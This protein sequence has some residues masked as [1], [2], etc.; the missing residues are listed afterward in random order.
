MTAGGVTAAFDRASVRLRPSRRGELAL[1]VKN[2]TT[3]Q[4][5]VA[6]EVIGAPAAWASLCPATFPL[7]PRATT[8][9]TLTLNLPS[10]SPAAGRYP[11]QVLAFVPPDQL[12]QLAA[13]S[14]RVPRKLGWRP[15]LAASAIVAAVGSLA[16]VVPDPKPASSLTSA[17]APRSSPRT[18]APHP[19]RAPTSV[20][21]LSGTGSRRSA[22]LPQVAPTL[23]SSP[24]HPAAPVVGRVLETA[25]GAPV[26]TRALRLD[27]TTDQLSTAP[28]LRFGPYPQ[29]TA[30]GGDDVLFLR[31]G[32]ALTSTAQLCR[33]GRDG[34]L[35]VIREVSRDIPYSGG[36]LIVGFGNR[37]V[38][39]YQSEGYLNAVRWDEEGRPAGSMDFNSVDRGF[40]DLVRLADGRVLLY[41]RESGRAM[42]L[43]LPLVDTPPSSDGFTAFV[44]R[45]TAKFDP[46]WSAVVGLDGGQVLLTGQ[47]ADPMAAE[48]DAFDASA[49]YQAGWLVRLPQTATHG[50]R[51]GRG[52]VLLADERGQGFVARV[53]GGHLLSPVPTRVGTG[54]QLVGLG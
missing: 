24:P 16:V 33:V 10:P 15:L 45:S 1:Q 41:D 28:A 18:S 9:T 26:I 11:V 14:V 21:I 31:S 35:R 40:T 51:V 37:W 12:V 2:D 36:A 49:H 20:G 6:L 25:P 27:G 3:A 23:T 4:V 48:L 53:S 54:R 50:T 19:T 42:V 47:A 17:P 30:V 13:A 29:V 5:T 7:A 52:R 32:D 39:T 34:S 8:T 46:G 43:V 22:S 44:A 38:L